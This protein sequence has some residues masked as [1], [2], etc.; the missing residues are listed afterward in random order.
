LD[1]THRFITQRQCPKLATVKTSYG[2]DQTIF[3]SCHEKTLALRLNYHTGHHSVLCARLWDN[4]VQVLD[5][6]DEAAVFFQDIVGYQDESLQNIRLVYQTSPLY[7]PDEY[8]PPEA[9]T[10]W[11]SCPMLKH[12]SYY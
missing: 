7:A 6:D 1:A 5:L 11:G 10:I 8:V 9:R 2:N 4:D 12:S 3:V